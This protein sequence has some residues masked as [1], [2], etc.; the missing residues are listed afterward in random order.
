VMKVR[1]R[2]TCLRLLN[3][4]ALA[5]LSYKNHLIQQPTTELVVSTKAHCQQ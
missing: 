3:S 1:T 5:K 2:S 4:L